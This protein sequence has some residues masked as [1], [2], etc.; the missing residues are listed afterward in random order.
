MMT[1]AKI[2]IALLILLCTAWGSWNIYHYFFDTSAPTL[3]IEGIQ[4]GMW[5]SGD[6]QCVVHGGDEYK[7]QDISVYLDGKL[8]VSRYKINRAHFEY[9]FPIATKTIPNGKHNLK[10]ELQD[11]SYHKNSTA[12]EMSFFVDNSPLQVAFLKT[13]QEF[14]VFQGRTLHIQFQVN[15][16]IKSAQVRALS[17]IY[18]CVPEA[19]NSLIYECFIPIKSDETPNEYLLT[20]EIFD[21]VGN[22]MSVENKCQVVLYPFKK[23]NLVLKTEKVKMENELGLNERQLELDV[24]EVTQ[25]SPMQKLWQGAF[26]IPCDMKGISTEFGTLRTTQE[27]GKYPHNAVDLLGTPK[28]VVWAAQDGI[29]VIKSRYAHSGLTIGI[30][31]GCGVITLYFHLDSFADINVGDS[32]KKG[33]PVGKLGE[34]GYAR[35]YHLHWEMRIGNIQVDPMQWVKHDF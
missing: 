13:D 2:I 7:V 9:T 34:S 27:R 5:C 29:V 24:Q 18:T 30:D 10:I 1:R 28:S 33:K 14:K 6:I 35:G 26:Y 12:Q 32:I 16:E 25:A 4:D 23:Q 19:P 20:F 15:K 31:H 17:Q 8:L 21:K 3:V 11:A 22:S